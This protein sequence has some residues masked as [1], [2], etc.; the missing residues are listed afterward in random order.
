MLSQQRLPTPKPLSQRLLL[1]ESKLGEL[2]TCG[3][4][5]YSLYPYFFVFVRGSTASFQPLSRHRLF[6]CVARFIP[7]LNSYSLSAYHFRLWD[8]AVTK[9]QESSPLWNWPPSSCTPF[10]ILPQHVHLLL[11][12]CSL[13]LTTQVLAQMSQPQRHLTAPL[14][15]QASLPHQLP[16]P[17]PTQSLSF[18]ITLVTRFLFPNIMPPP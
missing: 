7:S 18:L 9:G 10:P 6:T 1:G 5:F 3:P 8:T 16:H 4:D 2:P 12:L 14:P 17:H 13:L 11:S 15:H